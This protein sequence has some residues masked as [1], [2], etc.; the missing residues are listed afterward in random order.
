MELGT[1]A[2]ALL[3]VLPG[4]CTLAVAE[5]DREPPTILCRHD[6]PLPPA[7]WG[8]RL[9]VPTQLEPLWEHIRRELR[10]E[11]PD[12][13][14]HIWLEPLSL[15][16]REGNALFVRAPDHIRT[17]IRE[18]YLPLLTSAARRAIDAPVSI[19]IVDE[20]WEPRRR[21]K[22]SGEA[23]AMEGQRLHPKY[24][25]EQFVIGD[26]NRFAHAAALAVAEMPG[27]AYNP[28]FLH[29]APGL[30]KT[31]LL[32]AIGNYV[33]RFGSGLRVRY[34]TIEHFTTQFVNAVRNQRTAVFKD[35]FRRADVVL[36]DDVQFLADKRR[37]REEFFHMFNALYES[38][39]QVALTSDRG[40]EELTEL[41]DRLAERFRSG[42]VVRL[43]PPGLEVRR[44]ILEKRA[45][46]DGV[47]IDRAVLDEIA[48]SVSSSVRALEGALIRVVAHASLR[49]E[50]PTPELASRVLAHVGRHPGPAEP[51][52]DEVITTTAR[53]FGIEVKEL[54]A[55]TRRPTA[56]TARQVAMYLS[57]KLTGHSLLE[58]GRRFGGR[59]H[60]TVLHA[61]EK[62]ESRLESEPAI[63]TSVE[64]VQ[65]R[66]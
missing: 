24:T 41:E 60:T 3:A 32:H 63:R 5:G 57:R 48:R 46:L 19:E 21:R 29:G 16:G 4:G 2:L 51:G 45:Q 30:G 39:S 12:F 9:P 43:E 7:A 53:E 61:V 20:R 28:L 27:Q 55:K 25:F 23:D 33:V 31:H 49:N 34:A 11:A 44:V 42:L 50:D 66:L 58:I 14:F 64:R 26:G 8:S 37:T 54:L 40:P 56:V 59:D 18:R 52:I 10:H 65:A 22:E 35:S 38:G 13:K 36:I 1:A 6:V 17:W 15:A 47:A 62:I